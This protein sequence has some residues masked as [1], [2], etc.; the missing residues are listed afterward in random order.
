MRRTDGENRLPASIA[1]LLAATVQLLL[2]DRL[3]L[4]PRWLLPGLEVALLIVLSIANPVRLVREHPLL[5]GAMLVLVACMT[6]A[7]CFAALRLVHD[8]LHGKDVNSASAL[9]STGGAIYLTNIVVFALW[10]WQLD[11]GGP[12]ARAAGRHLH[13][14]FLFPQMTSPE[15]AHPDWEPYFVDYLYVSFTNAVAFSPTDTMPLTRWSKLLML[16]QSAIALVTLGLVVAR[17]VNVLN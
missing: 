1:I 2:P 13:P 17:G 3:S 10:F 15:M 5:R 9:F 14:D 6:I 12:F 4:G 8:L 7:N 16:I 11:R